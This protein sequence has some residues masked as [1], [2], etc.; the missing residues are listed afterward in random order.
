MVAPNL[1]STTEITGKTIAEWVTTVPTAVISNASNSNQVLRLNVL[2]VTNRG[3]ADATLTVTFYRGGV[4]YH[5]VS[6]IR[7][8]IGTTSIPLA[9][10]SS[11]YLEEGDALRLSANQNGL[12]QYVVSYEIMS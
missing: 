8:A 7:V 2:Y 3:N 10:D 9:K 11:I 12:L 4:D 6:G 5:V 1:I